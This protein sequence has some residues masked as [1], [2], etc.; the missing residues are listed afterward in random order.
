MVSPLGVCIV[1]AEIADCVVLW[2][3]PDAGMPILGVI[4]FL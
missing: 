2:A 4:H 3:S 1:A